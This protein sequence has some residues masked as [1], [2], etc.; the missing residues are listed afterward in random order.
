MR[1]MLSSVALVA[2][3]LGLVATE[4]HQVDP[5]D[6][7][8]LITKYATP[9]GTFYTDDHGENQPVPGPPGA[10]EFWVYMESNGHKGLQKG[11]YHQVIVAAM[12]EELTETAGE[13]D[14]C[15][16]TRHRK[17]SRRL[18]PDMIIF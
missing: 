4:A 17:H 5:R 8:A 10:S 7:A 13:R 16:T 1:R 3:A 12:G 9:G 14:G 18:Q 2:V 11:G 6:C 15:D